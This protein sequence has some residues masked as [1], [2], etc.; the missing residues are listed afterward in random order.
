MRALP[1]PPS[2]RGTVNVSLFRSLPDNGA[3][4]TELALLHRHSWV[5]GRKYEGMEDND[6]RGFLD[7]RFVAAWNQPSQVHVRL[8]RTWRNWYRFGERELFRVLHRWDGIR[9]PPGAVIR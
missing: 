8:G 5:R 2:L 4:L 7:G 6:I 9:L 1:S 3:N